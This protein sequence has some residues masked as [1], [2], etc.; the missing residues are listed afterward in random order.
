MTAPMVLD[1]ADG[2]PGLPG[3]RRAGPG[4]D[5]SRPA[6]SSSWTTCRPTSRTAVRQAIEATGAELRFLPPY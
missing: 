2:R 1:G 4:P 6:I 3:L 5:A